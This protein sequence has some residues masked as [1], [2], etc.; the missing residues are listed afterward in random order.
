MLQGRHLEAQACCRRAIELDA[1]HADALHLMGLLSLHTQQ[2]DHAIEWIARAIR[3][4]PSPEYLCNLA[5]ALKRQGRY[6]EAIKAVE[7][8]VQ[9]KPEDAGLWTSLGK[10]L[11][12]RKRDSEALLCFQHATRLD[13][14]QFE[15]VSLSG[16]LLFDAKRFEEALSHFDQAVRIK[17]DDAELWM[18]HGNALVNLE[19]S[20]EAL[21]SFQ[22]VLELDPSHVDAAYRCGFLLRGL[23]RPGEALACFDLCNRL[24]PGNAEVLEQRGLT[25]HDLERFE[26]A[27]TDNRQAHAL[28]PDNAYL[29]NNIGE[30]L[31]RLDRFEES[32]DWF[33]RALEMKPDFAAAL[34]NKG[35]ALVRL[36]RFGEAITAYSQGTDV[37]DVDAELG[38]G[39]LHLLIG[40]FEEGWIGYEARRRIEFLSGM[41]PKFDM[42]LWRGDAP[43]EG[44]SILIYAD[45]A[46]GDAIQF[47]RYLPMLAA[48]G[49]RVTVL[50][51]EPL[52][53]LF[54]GL[55][56][57]SES[58]SRMVGKPA[59]D[60]YCPMC[61]LPLAFGTRIDTIP[62]GIPY[63]PLPDESSVQ[64]WKER[65]GPHNRL[66]VGVVWSGKQ[67][68]D[69]KRS[70][71]LK[72]FSRILDVDATF[73][74][75]QKHPHETDK[76]VLRD[77]PVID[78]TDRI[79]DFAD[80]AA[81]VRCLD[82]V[83]TIDTSVAHLAGALGCRVWILLP[84]ISDW[85]WLL[86]R[87]DSPWYPTARLFRQSEACDYGEVLDRVK[88]E[89]GRLIADA[90]FGSHPSRA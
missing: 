84:Y 18:K 82:L 27:L 1:G 77:L 80:T 49:A 46:L 44:K 55:S 66:R 37:D 79:D 24:L 60:L 62:A 48:R 30:A 43:I 42:P 41:H 67:Q 11:L 28:N 12:E 89:I 85:R 22:R 52:R 29:C 83:V 45:E 39:Q 78:L 50:A 2:H 57:V 20:A 53:R 87:D 15:A 33:D 75:L 13:P 23:K 16:I 64:A 4:N 54:S 35:A 9:L 70:I 74:S 38:I 65:L 5:I 26:E 14:L 31:R 88:S 36:R 8:A 34:L 10:A 32:L 76:E 58:L 3:Q 63:L 51:T 47:S 73:V 7:K 6:E 25:L 72:M 81:L 90:G 86:D 40:N 71:P 61:S 19:R 17:P 59:F 68:P 69:P 56:G 21:P